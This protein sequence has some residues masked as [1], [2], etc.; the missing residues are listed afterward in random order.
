MYHHLGH[1]T[2]KSGETVE[3]GVVVGPDDAWAGRVCALLGHK[4][5]PWQWQ[6][7]VCV[8]RRDLGIDVRFY[9][10]HRG[11]VPF[12]NILVVEHAGV[13][14]FGHVF[15][16]PEDRRKHATS[17]LMA[18]QMRDF[19]ERARN[20]APRSDAT[21]TPGR[22]LYLGTGFNSPPYHIYASEGFVGLEP[23]SGVMTYTPPPITSTPAPVPSGR[24]S[25]SPFSPSTGHDSL[26]AFESEYFGSD[27]DPTV[28]EAVSWKH[29]PTSSP[30]FCSK[31]AG[32]HGVTPIVRM[33]GPRLLG[34]T[35]TEEA[36]LLM[37]RA[38]E[39]AARDSA[40]RPAAVALRN[41]RTDAVLGFASWQWDET[42]PSTA[43]I[44]V[45]CHGRHWRRAADML[46][47]LG[48]PKENRRIAYADPGAS[49]KLAALGSLGLYA[50]TTIPRAAVLGVKGLPRFDAVMLM[51]E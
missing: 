34:R 43:L 9:L 40:S 32:H 10:L 5:Q 30:L 20:A 18:L 24:A 35:L 39:S 17:L 38:N 19:K 1:V 51:S 26:A 37:I 44:D 46:A 42:W 41:T 3:A 11:G 13:G 12:S 27:T 16:K 47:A 21:N 29:W 23:G 36:T 22:A 45:F 14:L 7:G 6:N 33:V 31:H 49:E 25:A 2:L 50:A 28:I 15:T 8:T 4:S 48:I